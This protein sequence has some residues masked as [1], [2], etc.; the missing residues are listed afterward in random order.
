MQALSQ[1]NP[2]GLTIWDVHDYNLG[3]ARLQIISYTGSHPAADQAPRP[4]QKRSLEDL[5][6]GG[7]STLGFEPAPGEG[8][9]GEY[10][11]PPRM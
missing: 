10:L 11:G 1:P 4:R 2:T 8:L 3:R 6:G 7:D 9:Q 5:M